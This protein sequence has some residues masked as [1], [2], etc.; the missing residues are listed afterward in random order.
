[1]AAGIGELLAIAAAVHGDSSAISDIADNWNR[2]ASTGTQQ[3]TA[4]NTAVSQLST[5]WKGS[6]AQSF[7]GLMEKFAAAS[8][9]VHENLLVGSQSLAAA[10]KTIDHVQ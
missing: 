3:A 7:T 2:S 10:A 6:A 5:A 4:V 9:K 1:M 8:S